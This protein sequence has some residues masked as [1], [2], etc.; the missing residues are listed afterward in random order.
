MNKSSTTL[1]LFLTKLSFTMTGNSNPFF[2]DFYYTPETYKSSIIIYNFSFLKKIKENVPEGE[3]YQKI[4]YKNKI[5]YNSPYI[6]G[7][8]Q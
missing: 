5:L 4:P 2:S 8:L 3:F 6:R 1:Y 7:I